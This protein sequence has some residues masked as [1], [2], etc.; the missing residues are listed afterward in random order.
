MRNALTLA[1][2][3]AVWVVVALGAA[4]WSIGKSA[5]CPAFADTVHPSQ[6]CEE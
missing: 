6:A 2:V 5:D 4:W 3:V 1:L